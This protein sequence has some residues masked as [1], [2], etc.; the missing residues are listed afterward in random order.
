MKLHNAS[1]LDILPTIEKSSIDLI[2]NDLPYN[3]TACSWDSLIPLDK[4]WKEYERILKPD[5]IVLFT[6][7]QPF[8][9]LVVMSNL[10]W[11][12]YEWIWRKNQGTN[13]MMAKKQPLRN[14]EHVLVFS[15]NTPRYNPQMW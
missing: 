2:F 12:K 1:C 14:H 3:V 7:T 10:K 13:P 11:F 5:G 15:K 6:A 9:S 8:S 4:L